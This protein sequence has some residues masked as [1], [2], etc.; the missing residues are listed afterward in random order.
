MQSCAGTY[1]AGATCSLSQLIG[2]TLALQYM[3]AGVF[4][5]SIMQLS[6]LVESREHNHMAFIAKEPRV[7]SISRWETSSEPLLLGSRRPTINVSQLMGLGAYVE[8]VT[9]TR[10][11]LHRSPF[12]RQLTSINEGLRTSSVVRYAQGYWV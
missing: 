4:R 7:L 8:V 2:S 9:D 3:R 1:D 6:C 11:T 5:F 10:V 12:G